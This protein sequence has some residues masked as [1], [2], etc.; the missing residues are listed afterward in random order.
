MRDRSIS[1]RK[2]AALEEAVEKTLDL[3]EE[4]SSNHSALLNSSMSLLR[5]KLMKE[6]GG[7]KKSRGSLLS[8]LHLT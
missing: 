5:Q 6:F 7:E 8:S 3:A 2:M 4:I 1:H